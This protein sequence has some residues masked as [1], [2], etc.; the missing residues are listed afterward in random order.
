MILTLLKRFPKLR[1]PAS[2]PVL[3]AK[4]KHEYPALAEDFRVVEAELDQ[5]FTR[6]DES[7]LRNQ[8]RYRRQQITVLLGAIALSAL[9]GLQAVLTAQRWPS[10]VLAGLSILL[11]TS[12]RI[13]GENRALQAYL[14][15]RVKAERLRGLYFLYLSR[16]GPYAAEGRVVRLRAAVRDISDRDEAL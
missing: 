1:A 12:N 16:T 3:D 9:G 15:N 13:V 6:Y 4:V 2:Y 10:A 5:P 7:A 14:T 8:N 11:A